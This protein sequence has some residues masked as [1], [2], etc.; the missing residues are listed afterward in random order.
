MSKRLEAAEQVCLEALDLIK[1]FPPHMR[2][3]DYEIPLHR[4]RRVA[5]ALLEWGV[6][7]GR[8]TEEERDRA[9]RKYGLIE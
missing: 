7:A 4:V 1:A 8:F 2:P 6:L 3:G 9:K 5:A